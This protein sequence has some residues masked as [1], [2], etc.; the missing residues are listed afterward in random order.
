MIFHFEFSSKIDTYVN[1]IS[2]FLSKELN[3]LSVHYFPYVSEI[4]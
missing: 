2:E 3:R 4:L 1:I